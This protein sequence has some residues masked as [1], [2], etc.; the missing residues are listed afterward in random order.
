MDTIKKKITQFRKRKA[1]NDEFN[2]DIDNTIN[3]LKK[4]KRF[5]EFDDCDKNYILFFD[6]LLKLADDEVYIIG[7]NDLD[8]Y[9]DEY[10]I[11]EFL[12]MFT[13]TNITIKASLDIRL[14]GYKFEDIDSSQTPQYNYLEEDICEALSD[15][16]IDDVKL[17]NLDYVREHI[18]NCTTTDDVN[19][20]DWDCGGDVTAQ[21]EINLLVI[22]NKSNNG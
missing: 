1:E 20:F 14:C 5:D 10:N 16:E 8:D 12:E 9:I 2:K 17:L 11:D 13:L 22:S 6:S 3:L 18:F 21:V 7:E 19:E 4:L 15:K